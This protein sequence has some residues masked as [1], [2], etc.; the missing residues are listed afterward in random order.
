MTAAVDAGRPEL[1]A[2]ALARWENGRSV[3]LEGDPGMGKTTLLSAVAAAIG[4]RPG[5]T[6]SASPAE[7]DARMPFVT[8]IDLLSG[9]PGEHFEK[10]PAPALRIVELALRRRDPAHGGVDTLAVCLALLD[11]LRAVT[12]V[13]PVTLVVDDLQWVDPASAEV[14][15]FVV[16]RIEVGRLTVVAA[17]RSGDSIRFDPPESVTLTVGP[18]PADVLVPVVMARAQGLIGRPVADEICALSGGN[19]LFALEIADAVQRRGLRSVP[20]QPLPVPVHL[21]TLMRHRLGELPTAVRDTVRLAATAHR[22]TLGL[23]IRAG[24]SNALAELMVASEVGICDLDSHGV[25]S[26]GHPMLRAAVYAGPPSIVRMAL[27]AR[28]VQ[29]T[30]DPIERA[31]HL[32]LATGREDEKVAA[33]LSAAAELAGRRGATAAARELVSL[34]AMRT[35]ATDQ[36]GWAERK[37]A[38]ARYAH[39]AGLPGEAREAAESV[40]AA[41]VPARIRVDAWM[42]LFDTS[43]TTIG[44]MGAQVTA[45]LADAEGDP[46]LQ[47]WMRLYAALHQEAAGHAEQALAEAERAVRMA[48]EVGDRRAEVRALHVLL[49]AKTRLGL[50][51]GEETARIGRLLAQ[52]IDVGPAINLVHHGLACSYLDAD[53]YDEAAGVLHRAVR[54]AEESGML[55]GLDAVLHLLA[56]VDWRRGRCA[57]G[58]ATVARLQQLVVDAEPANGYLRR[59]TSAEAQAFTGSLTEAVGIA[60]QVI[61]E[62]EATGAKRRLAPLRHAL[63]TWCLVL[64]DPARAVAVLRD[65]HTCLS[66]LPTTNQRRKLTADLIE[67]LVGVGDHAAAAALLD[68]LHRIGPDQASGTATAARQRAAAVVAFA[69]GRADTALTLLAAA[70]DTCRS[71]GSPFELSR[72]LLLAAGMQRRRRRR[73][74]ARALLDEAAQICRAAGATAWIHRIEEERA[75]LTPRPRDGGTTLTPMQERIAALVVDGATNREIAAVLCIG[76]TTVEASLTQIYRRFCIRSRVELVRVLDTRTLG[77]A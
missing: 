20:G 45:A 11:L 69:E 30:T 50:P 65:A 36:A 21:E 76:V 23:L 60:G 73:A 17:V 46:H 52:R 5:L 12:E 3:I 13:T 54:Q 42:V 4:R 63:G 27:H 41:D 25:V 68:E 59:W 47:P 2:R 10:L 6:L 9:M 55:G 14:L 39:H 22:P 72:I 31:W 58:L 38:E 74:A 32:A 1:T 15:S 16:R 77:A 64:S 34:A 8:L 66:D 43:G 44:Q 26:F 37:L 51:H 18:L 56:Q 19:P 28:L 49:T 61:A 48:V 7:S 62:L 75:R 35:P 24:R 67:A 53:R 71:S 70:A 40:L 33:A 29:V 57:A